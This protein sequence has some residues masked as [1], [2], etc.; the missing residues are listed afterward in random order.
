MM[1][2]KQEL[3]ANTGDI[4]AVFGADLIERRHA[5]KAYTVFIVLFMCLGSA[6]YGYAGSIIST[7]L[8]QPSFLAYMGLETA[9][10]ANAL[11]S[12]MVSLYYVGG[13]GGAICHGWVSNAYGR[14][15]SII[16][17]NIIVLISGALCTG[18]VNPAMFIVFRFTIGWG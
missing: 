5:Y 15:T 18:A 11:T 10:N 17:A 7:T 16:V 3:E 4:S 1:A 6:S 2:N 13:V 8:G 14:K 9:P 12:A